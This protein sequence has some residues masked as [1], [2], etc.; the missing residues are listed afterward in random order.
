[1]GGGSIEHKDLSG[2]L[3][4]QGFVLTPFK[5]TSMRP[6]LRQGR[7]AVVVVPASAS[8]LRPMDVVLFRDEAAG[9]YVLHRLVASDADT[10]TTLGDHCVACER[11]PKERLVGRLAAIYR[12][13]RELSLDA[14]AYR[15][16][17]VLW[18]RPWRLRVRLVRI[19]RAARR[20]G[21]ALL[22]T[23]GL[24]RAS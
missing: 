20:R 7:D 9:H 17:V 3:N 6:L 5:G 16:Y 10:L 22:R 21:G 23:L 15:A 8:E 24:R 2:T 14:P 1:M 12:D 19:W 11:F 13:E 4:E 18:C